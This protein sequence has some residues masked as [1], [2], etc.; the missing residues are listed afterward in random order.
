MGFLNAVVTSDVYH[1]ISIWQQFLSVVPLQVLTGFAMWCTWCI[2]HDAGHGTVSKNSKY[3][4]V[5][6]RVVGEIT[7]SMV[8]L[9]PF[10]PWALSHKKHHLNHNHL[11]RDYSHQWF[12]RKEYDDLHPALQ[13]FHSIRMLYFPFL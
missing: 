7:H 10:V 1:R 12:V 11:H 2:G 3:G 9:T 4:K 8:C 5:V 6:N 13:F